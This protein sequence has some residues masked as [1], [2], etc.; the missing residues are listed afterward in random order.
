MA[1]NRGFQNQQTQQQ[2]P[3]PA[4]PPPKAPPVQ[5]VVNTVQIQQQTQPSEPE[6]KEEPKMWWYVLRDK[7]RRSYASLSRGQFLNPVTRDWFTTAYQNAMW[8][9][10]CERDSSPSTNFLAWYTAGPCG[11]TFHTD[12]PADNLAL[13][14]QQV[15]PQWLTSIQQKLMK[16]CGITNQPNCC[17]LCYF[18]DGTMGWSWHSD[19]HPMFESAP[20]QDTTM[21]LLCL[22]EQRLFKYRPKNPKQNDQESS[23]YL[24]DGDVL[25]MS[26]L[27]QSQYVHQIAID[28]EGKA[29]APTILITW[30]WI[31]N[32]TRQ[33]RQDYT[34]T[35]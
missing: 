11:C 35:S 20:N 15:P 1:G 17:E 34:P 32:H 33:C 22:G 8:N 31:V 4:P 5:P 21:I 9:S 2:Q 25:V 10:G 23:V 13:R 29:N 12:L 16:I 14:R 3:A 19:N 24:E 30:R 26:G 18:T 27:F 28:T 7:D 6:K